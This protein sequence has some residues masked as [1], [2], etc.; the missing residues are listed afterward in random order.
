MSVL[1]IPVYLDPIFGATLTIAWDIQTRKN[2]GFPLDFIISHKSGLVV[3]NNL[4]KSNEKNIMYTFGE[5]MGTKF[6]Y[7][8]NRISKKHV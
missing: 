8:K 3:S 5:N 6:K 1:W 7:H 2:F 4:D